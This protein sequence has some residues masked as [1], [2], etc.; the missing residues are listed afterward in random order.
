VTCSHEEGHEWRECSKSE[1]ARLIPRFPLFLERLPPSNYVLWECTRCG[2][3]AWD[4]T[5]VGD[6]EFTLVV[7]GRPRSAS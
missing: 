2:A 3:A 1:H 7:A 4:G 6:G 5:D